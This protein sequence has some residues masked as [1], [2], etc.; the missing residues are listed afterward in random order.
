M[1]DTSSKKKPKRPTL[2]QR[3]QNKAAEIE[4]VLDTLRPELVGVKENLKQAELL[5]SVADGLYEE[6]DKLAKKAPVDQATDLVVTHVNDV[7]EE[8]RELAADDRYMQRINAFVPA[9]DNPEHRDVVLMLRQLR[10]GLERCHRELDSREDKLT[11][12]IATAEGLIVALGLYI[13]HDTTAPTP[14]TLSLNDVS[15]SE[16]WLAGDYDDKYVV[17]ER[18]DGLDV[19]SYFA[20]DS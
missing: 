14:D 15:L 20:T 4:E 3:R 8:A 11:G 7:I 17:L 19:E 18:I 10:Q 5:K 16:E 6:M 1:S 9:G 13:E 12:H 2:R